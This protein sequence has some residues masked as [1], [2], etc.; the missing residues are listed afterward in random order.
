MQTGKKDNERI[1]VHKDYS[2]VT[3]NKHEIDFSGI[4]K[5]QNLGAWR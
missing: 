1:L 5:S 4:S 2:S 3:E